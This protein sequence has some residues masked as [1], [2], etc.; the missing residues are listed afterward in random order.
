MVRSFVMGLF[1]AASLLLGTQSATFAAKPPAD[2]ECE[3]FAGHTPG[4]SATAKGSAFN[5]AG[6]GHAAY[7]NAGAPSRYDVACFEQAQH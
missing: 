4:H 7:E 3:D 6:V 1:V 2:V 5:P